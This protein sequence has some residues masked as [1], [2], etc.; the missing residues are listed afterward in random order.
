MPT[1]VPMGIIKQLCYP[2]G[3]RLPYRV[4]VTEENDVQADYRYTGFSGNYVPTHRSGPAI[5]LPIT[6][7]ATPTVAGNLS[8]EK[9]LLFAGKPPHLSG[10]TCRG[11]EKE[12]RTKEEFSH[13]SLH[14]KV[15]ILSSIKLLRR[16][17]KCAICNKGT[18]RT[19]WG[20]PICSASCQKV[21]MLT[22]PASFRS[23]RRIVE[24][25]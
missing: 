11:C 5:V 19:K 14:C 22:I 17:N 6:A 2:K 3:R 7:T 15:L 12:V 9:Y 18:S 13:H 25:N 21:W 24:R 10:A 16:D 4:L 23:A 1:K 8:N 20:A